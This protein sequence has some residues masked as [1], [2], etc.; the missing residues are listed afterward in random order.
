MNILIIDDAKERHDVLTTSYLEQYPDANE[1]T[2][3]HAYD[4]ASAV[5]ALSQYQ[6]GLISFDHD[7]CDV[8]AWNEKYTGASIARFMGNN[9]MK[10]A[11]CIVHS[12][13]PEGAKNIISILK[14]AEVA[15]YIEYKPFQVIPGCDMQGLK[16]RVNTIKLPSYGIV[17]KVDASGNATITSELNTKPVYNELLTPIYGAFDAAI[18][19]IENMILGHYVAGVDIESPAYLEGIDS[20]VEFVH[21][22]FAA[23]KGL[24]ARQD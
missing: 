23:Y 8:N 20:I 2:I 5:N 10:C 1:H 13:N 6:F 17:I 18:C 14:S 22:T 12:H 9:L 3:Y 19:T 16:E 15:E 4:Y 24:Y 11:I 21:N 7:L